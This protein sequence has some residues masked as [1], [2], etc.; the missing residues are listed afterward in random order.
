MVFGRS[1][2]HMVMEENGWQFTFLL[3]PIRDGRETSI[4]D[5][6]LFY[7]LSIESVR[8]DSRRG[9]FGEHIDVH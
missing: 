6:L 7:N 8:G 3:Q 1:N 4:Q 9:A 2:Q 5:H